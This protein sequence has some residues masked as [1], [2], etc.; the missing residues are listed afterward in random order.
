[1]L[2]CCIF[3]SALF[4]QTLPP[5]FL[6]P[7][8]LLLSSLPLPLLPSPPP[9]LSFLPSPSLPPQ[10]TVSSGGMLVMK[11]DPN[12]LQFE[13]VRTFDG[14]F[15]YAQNKVCEFTSAVSRS[16]TLTFLLAVKCNAV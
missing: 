7:L 14:T 10:I 9:F 3:F 8:P 15:A 2:D 12:D 16:I 1:M 5:P 6:P 11:L 13:N 4:P